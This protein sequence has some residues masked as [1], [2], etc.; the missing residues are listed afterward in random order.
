M[1]DTNE[2]ERIRNLVSDRLRSSDITL[3]DIS[4]MVEVPT[5]GK[6]NTYNTTYVL[7]YEGVTILVN[8]TYLHLGAYELHVNIIRW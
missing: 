8:K 2:I 5:S 1:L 7:N 4:K 6:K 3:E